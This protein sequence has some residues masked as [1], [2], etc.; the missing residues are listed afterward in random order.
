MFLL[1]N[2]ALDKM[3]GP[4]QLCLHYLIALNM[5]QRLTNALFNIPAEPSWIFKREF[6]HP[7]N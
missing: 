3:I 4:L 7:S 5:G 2:K 1:C 6:N